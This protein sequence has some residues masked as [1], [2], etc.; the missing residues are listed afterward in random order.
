VVSLRVKENDQQIR[1][2][3]EALWQATDQG[4]QLKL[5]VSPEVID[6][7]KKNEKSLEFRYDGPTAFELGTFMGTGKTIR[8]DRFLISLTGNH[9]S[10]EGTN[11]FVT[12]FYG[13]RNYGSG[14]YSSTDRGL[15]VFECSDGG[16]FA[17]EKIK[18]NC[19]SES[20]R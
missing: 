5:M 7:I 20:S 13:T 9:A 2:S 14:P 12:L 3:A 16:C 4:K 10:T 11:P 8:L 15:C 19:Q 17:K 1:E 18:R 6:Q